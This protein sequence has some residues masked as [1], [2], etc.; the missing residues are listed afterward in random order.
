VSAVLETPVTDL[1][2]TWAWRALADL[3]EWCGGGTPSKQRSDFWDW[4]SIP[5]VS[6]KDMK[7]HRL[8]DT[9]DHIT[10]AAVE[11]SAAK[12]FPAKS[13]ALVVRSGILEH[14][15]PVALVPFEATANQDM[16]VLAPEPDINSDWAEV[17]RKFVEL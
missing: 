10:R 15:L 2:A 11:G 6:P 4:G 17:A 16:R 13:I 14:T 12:L 3:G 5:W 8:A 1:P 9:Q 7:S